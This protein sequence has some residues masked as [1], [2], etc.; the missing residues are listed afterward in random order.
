MEEWTAGRPAQESQYGMMKTWSLEGWGGTDRKGHHEEK[1]HLK[2]EKGE[3]L[4]R[5]HIHKNA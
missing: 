4:Q 2:W 3:K 5:K 1:K